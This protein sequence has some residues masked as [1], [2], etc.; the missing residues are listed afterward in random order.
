MND[1]RLIDVL[2]YEDVANEV[3]READIPL[4]EARD[5][6]ITA[7]LRY[8]EVGPLVC[9]LIAGHV[10]ALEVRHSIAVML[11]PDH[12]LTEDLMKRCPYRL[13][14]KARSGERRPK[15]NLD[16]L[17][18]DRRLAKLV[19]EL[20]K[21]F[22]RGSYDAAIKQVAADTGLGEETIRAAYDKRHANRSAN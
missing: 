15:I 9:F 13:V 3:A 14:A 10:P 12:A 2:P 7:F 8:G 21:K 11:A 20:L 16:I 6:V 1:D 19:A 22:G 4:S 5:R 17:L 18:R